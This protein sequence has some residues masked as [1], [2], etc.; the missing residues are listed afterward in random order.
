MVKYV[1]NHEGFSLRKEI[2]A[3]CVLI[4]PRRTSCRRGTLENRGL[5]TRWIMRKAGGKRV[6]P[7]WTQEGRTERHTEG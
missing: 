7:G 6:G 3:Q 1:C 2:E 5:H 4:W